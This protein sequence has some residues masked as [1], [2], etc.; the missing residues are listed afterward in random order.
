MKKIITVMLSLALVFGAMPV[1]PASA[2]STGKVDSFGG[3]MVATDNNGMAAVDSKGTL[4]MWG[5]IV[6]SNVPVV[7]MENVTAVDMGRNNMLVLTKDGKVFVRGQKIGFNVDEYSDAF[8]QITGLERVTAVSLSSSHAAA[9]TMDGSLWTWGSVGRNADGTEIYSAEPVKV[10]GIE[11]VKAVSCGSNMTAAITEDG[12]LWTWGYSDY[13]GNGGIGDIELPPVLSHKMIYQSTPMKIS[14]KNVVDVSCGANSMVAV[15]DDGSL[16]IWGRNDVIVGRRTALTPVKV[17]GIKDAVKVCCG[18][19]HV[20]VVTSDGSLWMWGRDSYGLLGIDNYRSATPQKVKYLQNV[21][22]ISCGGNVYYTTAAITKDGSVWTWGFNETN[23][24]GNGGM[25]NS[26]GPAVVAGTVK[27]QTVPQNILDLKDDIRVIL[28]GE[29]LEF[30]QPP[31]L[32]PG[33]RVLVPIRGIAE[34]MGDSVLWNNQHKAACILHGEKALIIKLLSDRIIIAKNELQTQWESKPL[35]VTAQVLNGRTL[36]PVRA[37]CE[38]LGAQVE[39][40]GSQKTVYITYDI[41][42]RGNEMSAQTFSNINTVYYA[43]NCEESGVTELFRT[44]SDDFMEFY[45]QRDHLLDGTAMGLS[46]IWSGVKELLSGLSNAETIMKSSIEQMLSAIPDNEIVTVDMEL[47]TDLKDYLSNGKSVFDMKDGIDETFLAA[48]PD[49]KGLSTAISGAGVAV[50]IANFTAE[51]L[52]VFASDYQMNIQ[53]LHTLAE[54]LDENGLLDAQLSLSL[55]A[56]EMEYSENFLRVMSNARDKL[57]EFT[58]TEGIGMATGGVFNIGTFTWSQIAKVTGLRDKGT[59]LKTFYGLFCVNESLDISYSAQRAKILGG[60]YTREDVTV[61]KQ[62]D[63][64]QRATKIKT[65]E[66]IKT[67]TNDKITQ[68]YCDLQ[69][70]TLSESSIIWDIP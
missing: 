27:T 15:T 63:D 48:H 52:A 18:E 6:S 40:D 43:M 35:D 8:T 22:D 17:S 65:Y 69:K 49:L 38:S 1:V 21:V 45:E 7:M 13:I 14:L 31:I 42:S 59:A 19:E 3:V 26:T 29:E 5:D 56:I 30:D 37:F 51:Q 36:V 58:I 57:A 64:M 62:L 20:G 25:S 28:N 53:Y 9:I 24:L 12:S 61:F 39:W 47:Y 46:D 32:D 10:S 44:A 50:D 11:K 70:K 33:N 66:S 34:A 4:W 23:A 60:S 2:N 16:W 55:S 68:D 54:V 41:N 67:I